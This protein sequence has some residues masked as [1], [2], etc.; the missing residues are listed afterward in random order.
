MSDFI[1]EHFGYFVFAGLM[2]LGTIMFM[3]I[4]SYSDARKQFMAECQQDLKAYECVALWNGGGR[5]RSR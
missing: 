2:V 5:A 3:G 4:E 1:F